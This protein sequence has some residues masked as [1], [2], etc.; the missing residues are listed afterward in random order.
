AQK[1]SSPQTPTFGSSVSTSA[2]I[3]LATSL[4]SCCPVLSQYSPQ[5]PRPSTLASKSINSSDLFLILEFNTSVVPLPDCSSFTASTSMSSD[6]PDP[7]VPLSTH[8]MITK[9]NVG[10]F[11]PKVFLSSREPSTV[12]EAMQHEHWSLMSIRLFF[13]I[14]HGP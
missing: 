11:K 8:H 1:H 12:G 10:V 7:P 3:P 14:R 9:S 2:F 13:V 5:T 4:D 6:P